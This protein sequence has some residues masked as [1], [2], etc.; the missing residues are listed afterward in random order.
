MLA[1]R[2]AE[3][4]ARQ[5]QLSAA[6]A[7]S[8]ARQ[9]PKRIVAR[10]DELDELVIGTVQFGLDDQRCAVPAATNPRE[11]RHTFGAAMRE[12]GSARRHWGAGQAGG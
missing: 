1:T 7:V 10:P 9:R 4:R 5:P 11:G 12:D 2:V 8:A 3:L 6:A